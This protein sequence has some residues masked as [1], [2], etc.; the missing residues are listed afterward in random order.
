MM[1]RRKLVVEKDK[2]KSCE[3]MT[4]ALQASCDF[5]SLFYVI[6]AFIAYDKTVLQAYIFCFL[7]V[8]D[9]FLFY[10]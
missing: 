9:L 6:T 4:T 5:W 7:S 2:S 8:S 1:K 10:Y 3:W